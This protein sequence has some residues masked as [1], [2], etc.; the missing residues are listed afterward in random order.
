MVKRK[1][2]KRQ[3]TDLQNITQ[4]TKDWATQTPVT[5]LPADLFFNLFEA[6]IIHVSLE[7]NEKKLVLAFN[8]TFRY[9]DDDTMVKRKRTKRQTTDL[10]NITQKTKDWATQT[11]PKTG[12]ELMYS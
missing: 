11:P 12:D 7:K 9:K 2:T 6:D 8:F 10:Q 1:R 3:T 4:K 5:L